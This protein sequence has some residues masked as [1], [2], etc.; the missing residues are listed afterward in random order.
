ME[1]LRFQVQAQLPGAMNTEVVAS[2][3][4]GV[5]GTTLAVPSC[6]LAAG[7]GTDFAPAF[8]KGRVAQHS[9]EVVVVSEVDEVLLGTR[10][11]K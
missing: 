7:T 4:L 3:G 2:F 11:P 6:H 8:P 5:E 9:E 10:P 1:P